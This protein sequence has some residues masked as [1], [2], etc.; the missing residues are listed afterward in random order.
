M[1][2][3]LNYT[4]PVPDLNDGFGLT[5][6]G[7]AVL[8]APASDGTIWVSLST[9]GSGRFQLAKFDGNTF[10]RVETGGPAG[11]S[12]ASLRLDDSGQNVLADIAE[13]PDGTLWVQRWQRHDDVLYLWSWDGIGWTEFGPIETRAGRSWSEVWA[14]TD[15][16]PG[17]GPRTGI[18]FGSDGSF[19]LDG[20]VHF[21]GERSTALDAPL[22]SDAET[23]VVSAVSVAPDGAI[24][25]V[26]VGGYGSDDCQTS[27]TCG[28]SA[29]GLYVITPEA[30]AAS[31]S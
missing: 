7:G 18:W 4:D 27:I 29:E 28:T 1:Y 21:D 30:V 22:A 20:L 11:P 12:R 17:A 25:V 26:M 19:W 16:H 23:T 8:V 5:D 2:V 3:D 15:E 24:W 13:A 10:D 14:G 6:A 9:P 31:E